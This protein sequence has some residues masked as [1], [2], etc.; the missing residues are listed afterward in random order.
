M[1]IEHIAINVEAPN[2][3]A[4]WLGDHLGMRVVRAMNDANETQFIVDEAG[5]VVIELYNN[6]ASPM[7][8]YRGMN[9]LVFHIA[10][11]VDDVAAARERLIAAGAT[12][13]GDIN[14]TPA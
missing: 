14:T 4:Q 3:M 6:P 13:E 11:S 2:K 9:P 10:F 8:D 7:P 5:R 12:A 1:N